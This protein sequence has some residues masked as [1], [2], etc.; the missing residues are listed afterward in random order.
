MNEISWKIENV[1]DFERRERK[2]K[3]EEAKAKESEAEVID[4]GIEMLKEMQDESEKTAKLTGKGGS[5]EKEDLQ[6]T[7]FENPTVEDIKQ[8]Q[9]EPKKLRDKKSEWINISR[10]CS[11]KCHYCMFF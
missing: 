1:F 5:D 6:E 3:R 7:N 9:E 11:Q 10:K 2:K 4:S 8:L